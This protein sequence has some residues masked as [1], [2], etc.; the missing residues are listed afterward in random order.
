MQALYTVNFDIRPSDEHPEEESQEVYR[1]LTGHLADWLSARGSLP[2]PSVEE[3]KQDGERVLPGRLAAHGDRQASWAVAGDGDTH[4]LRL[5]LLQPLPDSPAQFVTRVTVSRSGA[6]C[7]LRVVMGRTIPDGWIAPVQDPKLRRP[8]L[9]RQVLKDPFLNVRVLGQVATG[10]YEKVRDERSATVLLDALS[11][12]ERL[13]IL[14]AQPRDQEAWKMAE[15]ASA[16]LSGLAQVVTLNYLTSQVVRKRYP[17]LVVPSGG[18]RLVWPDLL[19]HHPTHSRKEICRPGFV[20]EVL[21]PRLAQLSVIAR[22]SDIAWDQARQAASRAGARRADERIT[23]ARVDGDTAG[24]LAALRDKVR[25]LVD[26]NAGLSDLAQSFSDERDTARA[27]AAEA[28]VLRQ[29]RD[30]WQSQYQKQFVEADTAAAV[31]AWSDVPILGPDPGPTF[32]SLETAAEGHIVF[33]AGAVRTWKDARY[34]Y[35]EE[36]TETLTALAQAAM[37]L[38]GSSGNKPRLDQWF[39]HH[40]LRFAPSDDKLKKNKEKR[41]FEFEGERRDGLPHI[42]VRDAVSPNEVGRIYF[43]LDSAKQRFVVHHVGLHL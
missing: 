20:T 14:L 35:P 21:M 19:L 38:Y 7:L 29:D 12:S 2:G 36:M 34:P 26:E 28:V 1:R 18:A 25:K 6:A 30:Y 37:E 22:G 24:E 5:T 3:L 43:A 4:A 41:Y 27:E 15:D 40:G 8:Q 31:D 16:Q 9:L 32:A 23:R 10:R 33:T 39:R 17:H 42:K 13:P 11:L